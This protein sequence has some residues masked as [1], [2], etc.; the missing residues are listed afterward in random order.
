MA[1]S[2]RWNNIVLTEEEAGTNTPGTSGWKVKGKVIMADTLETH[3]GKAKSESAGPVLEAARQFARA[4][5]RSGAYKEYLAAHDSLQSD[6]DAKA[7]FSEHQRRS[8]YVQM[9]AQWGGEREQ[10]R[11][12]LE[13][14]EQQ[15]AGNAAITRYRESQRRLIEELRELNEQMKSELGFDVAAM[16]RP[17]DCNCG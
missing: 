5:T 16:A 12:A 9:A 4:I 10:D 13:R 6:A 8:Q 11:A 17:H 2:F 14:L 15:M 7:M 1:K 3:S